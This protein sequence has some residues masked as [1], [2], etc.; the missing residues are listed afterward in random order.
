MSSNIEIS[1]QITGIPDASSARAVAQSVRGVLRAHDVHREIVITVEENLRILGTTTPVPIIVSRISGPWVQ[2]ITTEITDAVA[3]AEPAATCWVDAAYPDYDDPGQ[4]RAPAMPEVFTAVKA[5]TFDPAG[6][7]LA[8]AYQDGAVRVWDLATGMARHRMIAHDKSA[9]A[10]R[11]SPD[12]RRF[13]TCGDDR[14]V[15]IWNT[16][17]GERVEARESNRHTQAVRQ[18]AYHPDGRHVVTLGVGGDVRIWDTDTDDFTAHWIYSGKDDWVHAIAVHPHGSTVAAGGKQGRVRLYK[19]DTGKCSRALRVY[20]LR[21]TA[22]AYSADAHY[23]AIGT[24]GSLAN[25]YEGRV[26]VWD[27]AGKTRVAELTHLTG[28]VTAVAFT[29][30]GTRLAALARQGSLRLWSV[31]DGELLHTVD[32]PRT[33][34]S[35][36]LSPD[37]RHLATGHRHDGSIAI[38]DATTGAIERNL[39]TPDQLDL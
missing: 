2:Q 8:A 37:G 12:G 7:L 17:T 29:P 21:P 23:L 4:V 36:D 22:L 39:P 10:V 24:D 33:I 1:F 34:A 38:R 27:G 35:F 11:F 18:L 13:A 25:A 26:L 30:D 9:Q 19:S 6:R 14:R 15:W 20:P 16:A 31:P 28:D 3:A 32:D 5:V